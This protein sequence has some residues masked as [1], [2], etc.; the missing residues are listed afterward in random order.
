M[1]TLVLGDV[2]GAAKALDQ[3]LER[4][5]FDRATDRLIVLGDVADG[6]PQTR[7]VI[8]TILSIPNRV[9]LLGNHDAWFLEW[10]DDD[11]ALPSAAWYNQG[12]K[13]TLESYADRDTGVTRK[14]S[15]PREHVA[16]LR[17][18]KL[19]HEEEGRMFVHAGWRGLHDLHPMYDPEGCLWDRSLW[20]EAFRREA[21]AQAWGE[22]AA[23][24]TRFREV[25]IGHTTTTRHGFTE[26]VQRCEVWNLDQGAGWEGR[27]SLMDVDTKE[28]WQSDVVSTLY[29]E[30]AGRRRAA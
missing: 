9:C 3:V 1:R 27:L 22:T 16:Y 26:P 20:T 6:G 7:E 4:S 2:H 5:G 28:F 21:I 8:D 30:H 10:L 14:A 19:W 25:F 18:G 23:P 24:L 13:A 11:T 15:I 12:G 17:A 29:P